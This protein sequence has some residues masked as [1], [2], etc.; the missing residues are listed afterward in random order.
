MASWA[1]KRKATYLSFFIGGIL[2]LIGLPLFLFLYKAPTCSDGIQNGNERGIDCGGKCVRVC[3]AEFLNPLILWARPHKIANG[4]YNL[5]AYVENPNLSGA[6]ENIPYVFKLYDQNG[7]IITE[8]RGS[9]YLPPHKKIIAF[10]NGVLTGERIPA[11]VTFEFIGSV[12]WD[13]KIEAEEFIQ[14]NEKN[15][16]NVEN[17]PRLEV[18]LRNKNTIP[19]EN[20]DVFA[21]LYD[22]NE[23]VV[24]FSKTIVD[25]LG[26]NTEEQVVFTWPL[27][28]DFPVATIEVISTVQP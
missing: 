7:L 12:P 11:R 22:I 28:F 3:S 9:T 19:Y 27:P 26:G 2:L 20:I 15:V 21:I 14:V 10:E 8:R 23:N 4:V 25:R 1:T 6:A 18:G 13:K 16:T 17:R 5:A 24:A